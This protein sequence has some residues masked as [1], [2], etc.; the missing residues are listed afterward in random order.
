[1]T[2]RALVLGGGGFLG[3]AWLVGAV[4]ALEVEAGFDARDV[5]IIVGTSAGA[6][7]AAQLACGIGADELRRHH[8]GVPGPQDLPIS[9]EYA[10]H[11]RPPL[12]RA[13]FGSPALLSQLVRPHRPVSVRTSLFG[14]LPRGRGQLSEVDNMM[15]HIVESTGFVSRWPGPPALWVVATDYRTGQRRVFGRDNL[16]RHD[17]DQVALPQAV[18][19]SCSIPGW[20]EPAVIAGRAYV[21]G[22]AVSNTS[23]DLLLGESIDEVYALVPM[24]SLS[25][26]H[27][28]S[29][30]ARVERRVRASVTR[31]VMRDA[32][33]LREQ[34]KRVAVV[35]PV[36][37]DLQTMGTNLMN[38]RHRTDV[39]ETAVRTAAVQLRAELVSRAWRQG[40]APVQP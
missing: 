36:A 33:A 32:A 9:F 21:D 16:N 31:T 35:T 22:G 34:G 30:A 7:L 26:D 20:Y 19:A 28:K 23:L 15:T 1:V 27:P 37:E 18:V 3:F 11:A 38:P 14:A 8:Q 5:D 2:T 6:I 4:G 25:P 17:D 13:R 40:A 10:E 29:L 12:P 39:L 24:A